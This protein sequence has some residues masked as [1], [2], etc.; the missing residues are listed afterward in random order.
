MGACYKTKPPT[1]LGVGVQPPNKFRQAFEWFIFNNKKIF[2]LCY[3][4]LHLF[5]YRII[6]FYMPDNLSCSF[7]RKF[8]LP[9]HR[10]S[11]CVLHCPDLSVT[12]FKPGN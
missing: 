1:Y 2:I 3:F 11:E 12:A 10:C 4:V 7:L 5:M 6:S 8:Y 9:G